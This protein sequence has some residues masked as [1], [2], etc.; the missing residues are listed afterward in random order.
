L[1]R[2]LKRSLLG[3]IVGAFLLILA[4][5]IT[6][7]ATPAFT[8]LNA[9][10]TTV[11]QGQ[12]ITFSVRT[13]PEARY[14]FAMIDGARAQ[15][16]RVNTDAAGNH[17]WQ[18]TVNPTRSTTVVVFANSHNVEAGAATMSIPVTVTG[19]TA[20]DPGF[21]VIPLPPGTGNL[22]NIGP[23]GIAN[24]R[25]TPAVARGQVRLTL[26]TGPQANYVWVRFDGNLYARGEMIAQSPAGYRT[27]TIDFQPRVWS[28]QQ[29]QVGA[30]RTFH[31]T[32]A[33]LQ[34][35]QLTLT[36]PYVP[37][38]TPEIRN[39]VLT[40]REVAPGGR[41][42]IRITTNEHVGAVWIRDMDGREFNARS[43]APNTAT[44]RT[45]EV[46][47]TPS[48]SGHVTI[49]ANTTRHA[50][51][52]VT[53]QESITVRGQAVR[54]ID[55]R[56]N[57]TG[58]AN[59]ARVRVTTNRYAESVSVR[60]HNQT[61]HLSHISGTTGNRVWE[62]LINP[63]SLDIEVRAHA[64]PTHVG[65]EDVLFIRSWN[66][67]YHGDDHWW[68]DPWHDHWWDYR[69]T[70]GWGRVEEVRVRDDQEPRR[71]GNNAARQVY[72]Y[73]ITHGSVDEVRF[74]GDH[75]SQSQRMSDRALGGGRREWRIRLR[76][77]TN[78]PLGWETFLIEARQG[79]SVVGDGHVDVRVRN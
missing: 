31:Y 42:T 19:T 52:A 67:T 29:V 35:L 9:D 64:L 51:G 58:V 60:I 8:S 53:R 13:T 11:A 40:P 69:T 66:R 14:V 38:T 32:G 4:F 3:A 76:I 44:T 68:D 2:T 1:F 77:A 30:N 50:T 75:V 6:A 12:S 55:A 57:T 21:P 71:S 7:A 20:A 28:V 61:V 48:R 36:Q 47:F 16:T 62:A 23:V 27:W 56:A 65:V 18:V 43:I 79:G 17:N 22:D 24:L 34:S 39:A 49:F 41:Q 73:V 46:E 5:P 74:V 37:V 33:A 63:A 45:W 59:E 10:R 54:I 70:T 78:T 72:V 25:E 26:N 15:G